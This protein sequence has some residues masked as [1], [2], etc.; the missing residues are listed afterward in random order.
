[1]TA[2][3][4]RV[5]ICHVFRARHI[6]NPL[7]A[8]DLVSKRRHLPW[9][10]TLAITD[11]RTKQTCN[12]PID[13]PDVK[14]RKQRGQIA[15][16]SNFAACDFLA[17]GLNPRV[18]HEGLGFSLGF[19]AF[20]WKSHEQHYGEEANGCEAEYYQ[21][22]ASISEASSHEGSR[23]MASEGCAGLRPIPCS[24]REHRSCASSS[25]AYADCGGAF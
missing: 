9:A 14:G 11:N 4:I 19:H 17:P 12:L 20:L 24:A 22:R 5:A 8:S 3:T 7:S 15:H 21:G 25:V 13:A 10:D 1:M 18:E 6:Y 23:R 16:G 2:A